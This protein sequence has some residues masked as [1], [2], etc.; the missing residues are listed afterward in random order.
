LGV[1]IPS[2]F[3]LAPCPLEQ[4]MFYGRIYSLDL[5][6]DESYPKYPPKVRFLTKI[7]MDVVK[8]D[9][10]IDASRFTL[11]GKDWNPKYTLEDVLE[12]L[13]KWMT[14]SANRKLKQPA[15][16]ASY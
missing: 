13:R 9:G 6:C 8:S 16:G 4:T 10:N 1:R 11:L 14:S 12:N 7:N 5:T 3:V 2:L 15:E